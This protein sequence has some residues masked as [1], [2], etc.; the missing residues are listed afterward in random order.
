VLDG[1]PPPPLPSDYTEAVAALVGST[2]QLAVLS[3]DINGFVRALPS[4]NIER[5]EPYR[6]SVF[7]LLDEVRKHLALAGAL[8]KELRGSRPAQAK[9]NP[10][11][12]VRPASRR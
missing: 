7:S 11:P 1:V 2:D 5:L 9:L 3:S 4:G 8:L 12:S 10:A 6:K